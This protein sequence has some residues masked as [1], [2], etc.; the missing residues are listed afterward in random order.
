MLMAQ[1][2]KIDH[3]LNRSDITDAQCLIIYA[4]KGIEGDKNYNELRP[5]QARDILAFLFD[6]QN[7]KGS[8]LRPAI[9][10]FKKYHR[11]P[12]SEMRREFDRLIKTLRPRKS[13]SDPHK[14]NKVDAM[15]KRN[16]ALLEQCGDN[17]A[18]KT[19]IVSLLEL[20]CKGH[21]MSV[22]RSVCALII[23]GDLAKSNTSYW[24]KFKT[25]IR[26]YEATRMA[27]EKAVEGDVIN[28]R[29]LGF[30]NKK[31]LQADIQKSFARKRHKNRKRI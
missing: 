28:P 20:P 3:Y 30:D 17:I 29:N 21:Q 18:L 2:F 7:I 26:D 24:T 19:M 4:L 31:T 13:L 5:K 25:T 9:A 11:N 22:I 23:S 14:I 10:K 6:G 1:N 27:F 12:N 16:E 8:D 15:I